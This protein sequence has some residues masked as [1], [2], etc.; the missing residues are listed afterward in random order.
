M[1]TQG[2]GLGDWESAIPAQLPL[3]ASPGARAALE[4]D[5]AET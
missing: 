3:T 5:Q 4:E 1:L 2:P